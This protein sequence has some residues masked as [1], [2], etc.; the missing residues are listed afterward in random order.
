MTGMLMFLIPG[1][2][3]WLS[4]LLIEYVMIFENKGFVDSWKRSNDLMEGCKGN[5]ITF[6]SIVSLLIVPIYLAKVF[7]NF[8]T[9]FSALLGGGEVGISFVIS[10]LIEMTNNLLYGLYYCG[11]CLLYMKRTQIFSNLEVEN[12]D[13]K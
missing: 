4:M 8:D 11:T 7:Y 5:F 9:E 12:S 13:A 3:V 10:L 1:I 2:M 6:L